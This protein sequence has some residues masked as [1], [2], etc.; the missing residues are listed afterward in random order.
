MILLGGAAARRQSPV[1]RVGR[2][3]GGSKSSMAAPGQW[4]ASRNVTRTRS[5]SS[6]TPSSATR[7]R[8]QGTCPARGAARTRCYA[9]G[10]SRRAC[11]G[12]RPLPER[13]RAGGDDQ[14]GVLPGTQ[15]FCLNQTLP[16]LGTGRGCAAQCTRHV[17]TPSPG[18]ASLPERRQAGRWLCEHVTARDRMNVGPR[19]HSGRGA[20]SGSRTLSCWC[21]SLAV[22][23]VQ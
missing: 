6:G 7:S 22:I 20:G 10:L 4:L 11:R 13:A 15:P 2:R 5:T 9:W 3:P 23:A 16:A 17:A 21:T 8:S 18:A 19:G 1:C 12:G 14:G